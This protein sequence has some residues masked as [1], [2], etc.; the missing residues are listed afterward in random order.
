LWFGV[1]MFAMLGGML[2]VWGLIKRSVFA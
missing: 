2:F 1:A